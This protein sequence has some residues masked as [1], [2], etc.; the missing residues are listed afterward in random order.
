[1]PNQRH[2]LCDVNAGAAE[3]FF[4]ITAAACWCAARMSPAQ[5]GYWADQDRAERCAAG[6]LGKGL[7]APYSFKNTEVT[8]DELGA[9]LE[10]PSSA[11]LRA[12]RCKLR[13]D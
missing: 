7:T 3:S 11:R 6:N 1:M 13:A 2:T 5:D 4:M 10:P 8:V 9:K 12:A